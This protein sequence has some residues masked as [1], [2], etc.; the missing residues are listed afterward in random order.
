MNWIL[1]SVREADVGNKMMC[2]CRVGRD[3]RGCALSCDEL[4]MLG[5]SFSAGGGVGCNY[6]FEDSG[7]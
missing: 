4:L 6:F 1:D 3:G 7:P 5:S 2:G